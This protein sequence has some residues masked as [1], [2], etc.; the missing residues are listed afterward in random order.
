MYSKRNNL[1][2]VEKYRPSKI[3]NIV[4]QENITKVIKTIITN[5]DMD[6]QHMLFYGPSGIGKTTT[7]IALVKELFGPLYRER[8]LELNASDER[9]INTV[10]KTIKEFAKLAI[11]DIPIKGYKCPKYKVIILDEA[12]AMTQ[13]SQFA[14]RRIIEQFSYNT[15]FILICNYITKIIEPL[16]SRC[17]K[18]RFKKINSESIYNVLENICKNENIKYNNKLFKVIN[19]ITNGDLRRAINMLQKAHMFSTNQMIDTGKLT[20]KIIYKITDNID[21]KIIQKIY[22]FICEN[23]Y[24]ELYNLVEYIIAQA[25]NINIILE[26]LTNLI[27]NND[28]NDD[29]KALILLKLSETEYNLSNNSDD[30]LQLFNIFS[31]IKRV[32]HYD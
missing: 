5:D 11:N 29:K 18:Y 1:P 17:A 20:E 14:L 3:D 15:R 31:Y 9:G 12:D 13:G 10:R 19:D 27:I 25:Y 30:F 2:W 22:N 23:N 4:H 26:E 6:L 21:K 28:I 32:Y 7:A 24:N 8:V 16:T